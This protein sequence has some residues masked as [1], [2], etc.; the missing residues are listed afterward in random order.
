VKTV[1]LR[2]VTDVRVVSVVELLV[3]EVTVV[4][5]DVSVELLVVVSVAVCAGD[6]NGLGFARDGEVASSTIRKRSVTPRAMASIRVSVDFL[7]FTESHFLT[8]LRTVRVI[9]PMIIPAKIDSHGKPGIPG[10]W[11]VLLLNV[12][13]I[14]VLV[15][16]M[17]EVVRLLVVV[18][19]DSVRRLVE[20]E[21]V[22]VVALVEVVVTVDDPCVEVMVVVPAPEPEP[23][24]GG[25]NGSRWKIPS[26]GVVTDFGPAPTA[27]PSCVFPG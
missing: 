1:E 4:D 5:V 19:V 21:V 20:T 24:I 13:D 10:I 11:S 9:M 18:R 27:H 14:S 16:V 17:V 2:V 8:R 26:S 3:E 7:L 22:V 6:V 12:V 25:F 23:L 15:F